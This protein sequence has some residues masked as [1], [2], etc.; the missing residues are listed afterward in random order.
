MRE[1]R[2]RAWHSKAKEMLYENRDGDAFM[3]YRENQ[4]VEIM[5][6][7]GLYDKNRKGIYDQDKVK[8]FAKGFLDEGPLLERIGVVQW[9]DEELGWQVVVDGEPIPFLTKSTDDN[10]FEIIGNTYQP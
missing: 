9:S 2:F 5:Q 3:W 7:T 1:L 8:F 10:R 4:P 6:F